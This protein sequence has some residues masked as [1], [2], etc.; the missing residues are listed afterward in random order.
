MEIKKAL[1]FWVVNAW[2][3]AKYEGEAVV[4]FPVDVNHRH[5]SLRAATIGAQFALFVVPGQHL[6]DY[7]VR[8]KLVGVVNKVLVALHG[9]FAS[10]IVVHRCENLEACRFGA[11]P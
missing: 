5:P 11:L 4:G 9:C 8:P 2:A 6:Q 3:L 10:P 7:R 1:Y